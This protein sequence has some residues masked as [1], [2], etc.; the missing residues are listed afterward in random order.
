MGYENGFEFGIL[1]IF[2]CLILI[3]WG[4]WFGLYV[5]IIYNVNLIG[6]FWIEE[7]RMKD[8]EF[9]GFL[10]ESRRLAAT[11]HLGLVTKR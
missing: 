7:V 11:S 2:G 6:Y 9:L 5:L 10:G 4:F 1:V 3:L 8:W